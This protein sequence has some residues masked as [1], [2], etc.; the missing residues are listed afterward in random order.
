MPRTTMKK[1]RPLARQPK[2][3][4]AMQKKWSDANFVK[5]YQMAKAGLTRPQM[6]ETFGVNLITFDQWRQKYPAFDEAVRA[7]RDD[8]FNF[9]NYCYRRLPRSLQKVWDDINA[10][11]RDAS[12]EVLEQLLTGLD[13]RVRKYLWVHALACNSFRPDVA[14][15]KLGVSRGTVDRWKEDDPD[16]ADLC[17]EMVLTR[18]DWGEGQLLDLVAARHPQATMWWNRCQNEDRGYNPKKKVETEGTLRK[19]VDVKVVQG[20]DD[21]TLRKLDEALDGEARRAPKELPAGE[22]SVH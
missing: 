10:V 8:E 16:F 15:N 21:E 19:T 2:K 18:K 5:A 22:V 14:N 7:G 20:L 13:D 1:I 17:K 12:I 3:H 6:A 4:A 11:E 9:S